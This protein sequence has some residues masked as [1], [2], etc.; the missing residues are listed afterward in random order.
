MLPRQLMIGWAIYG[1]KRYFTTS[2]DALR[3]DHSITKSAMGRAPL[4]V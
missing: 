1:S 4:D 2:I 3:N